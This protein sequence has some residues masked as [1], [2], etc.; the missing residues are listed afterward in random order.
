MASEE[1]SNEEIAREELIRELLGDNP[2]LAYKKWWT[3]R[4]AEVTRV[5]GELDEMELR[6]YPQIE[7]IRFIG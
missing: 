5:S 2:E 7:N 1:K 3:K 6:S 4:C